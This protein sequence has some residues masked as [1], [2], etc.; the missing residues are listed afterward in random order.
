MNRHEWAVLLRD[1]SGWRTVLPQGRLTLCAPDAVADAADCPDVVVS[2]DVPIGRW[3]RF[4]AQGEGVLVVG[5]G[6]VDASGAA[7]T[8]RPRSVRPGEVIRLGPVA[9]VLLQAVPVAG[10]GRGPVLLRAADALSAC[11]SVHRAW[12]ELLLA[13]ST[14]WPI[15]LHGASGTGKELAARLAHQ[16]SPRHA[17]PM[18]A[19]SA[20]ALPAGTMHAE[21]FGARRGAYT[22][23]VADREG[24][25]GRADGGTLL[26]DEVGEL[27]A[28]AQAALLRVLETGEITPLGDRPRQVDVR[29]LAATHR[30]LGAMVQAGH[31][32]LDLYHRLL[33]TAVT[34]P[35]LAAR[36]DDAARVLA[37]LLGRPLDAATRAVV[38]GYDWPGNLR[39]LRNVARRV[40][41]SIADGE[42]T[43][44]DVRAAI[45][46]GAPR[47]RALARV[48]PIAR[49]A[50]RRRRVAAAVA[51]HASTAAACRASG[52]P[53]ASFYRAL[54]EL[55]ADAA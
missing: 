30:D 47:Q 49:R 53:R 27:D 23:S 41:L 28:G 31:F 42:P 33:V 14:D 18:V 48:D 39:E 50:E 20:A 26:I 9:I 25:F 40:R 6:A 7:I 16:A 35:P 34:L 32:R 5:E 3:L 12:G 52:L 38:Q 21:L 29:V 19:I 24:A 15:L 10:G 4:R 55:R 37:E 44:A 2:A 11:P 54:R 13:A 8:G 45:A 22:G 17:Q 43:A 46:A 51:D 1:R 36:A